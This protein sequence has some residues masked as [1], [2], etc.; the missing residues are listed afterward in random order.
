[1]SKSVSFLFKM[2]RTANTIEKLGQPRKL[3]RHYKNKMLGRYL[4]RR[5][6]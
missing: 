4:I 5:V 3:P 6:W 2:A 1:M